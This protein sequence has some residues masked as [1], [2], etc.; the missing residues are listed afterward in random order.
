MSLSEHEIGLIVEQVKREVDRKTNAEAAGVDNEGAKVLIPNFVPS[1]DKAIAS[2]AER[3][4]ND[5]ELVFLSPVVFQTSG[6]RSRSIDWKTQP[7]DLVDLLV[8]AKTIVLLAPSTG[9]LRRLGSGQEEEGV[10]ELLLR[11]ILWGK[12]FDVVMDFNPPKFRRGTCFSQIAEAIDSLCSMGV[13]FTAY[14]P[15]DQPAQDAYTLLTERDVIDAKR[16]G[17]KTITCTRDAIVTPLAADAA[18]ELQIN[19]EYA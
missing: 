19:I 3:C 9:L 10:G 4:G 5:F 7:N 11:R 14:Q 18:K 2:V 12:P 1:P 8:N 6:V 13:R 17:G 16:N 15:A